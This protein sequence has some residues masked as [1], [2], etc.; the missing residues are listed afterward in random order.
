LLVIDEAHWLFDPRPRMVRRP[1][2]VD[3]IN[4]DLNNQGVHVAL[5]CTPQLMQSANQA[6]EQT[7]WNFW[8]FRRRAEYVALPDANTAPDLESVARALAPG[9]S[10]A[11]IDLMVG[12]A[13]IS[14]RDISGL[15]D[16]AEESRLLASAAGRQHPTASDVQRAIDELLKSDKAFA[17]R[18]HVDRQGRRTNPRR[19]GVPACQWAGADE[20]ANV[21]AEPSRNTGGSAAP[22]KRFDAEAEEL[23]IEDLDRGEAENRAGLVLPLGGKSGSR[24][25][26]Q[27]VYLP[28]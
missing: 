9:I 2:L 25:Q 21:S 23:A 10:A 11:G 20:G 26:T 1:E 8:Q 5:I 12:Y 4:T 27:P 6:V 18:L 3:W 19:Q 14:K 28:E 24:R 22:A 15:G 17:V 13:Q 7:G 16:I